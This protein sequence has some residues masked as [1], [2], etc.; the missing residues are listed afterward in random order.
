MNGAVG[1]E[2]LPVKR[3]VYAQIR[4]ERQAVFGIEKASAQRV[5]AL[6]RALRV[7]RRGSRVGAVDG[8]K[9]TA[10][11]NRAAGGQ[12]RTELERKLQSERKIARRNVH[13]VVHGG[14]ALPRRGREHHATAFDGDAVHGEV[15]EQRCHIFGGSRSGAFCATAS[16]GRADSRTVPKAGKIPCAAGGAKHRNLRRLNF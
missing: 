9:A 5:E 8:A 2:S 4:K 14:L 10:D 15:R 6:D 7:N 1:G 16:R 11:A 13:V 3:T 12:V